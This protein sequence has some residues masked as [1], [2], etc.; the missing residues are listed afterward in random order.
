M[1]LTENQLR[2]TIRSILAEL[3]SR[4]KNKKGWLQHS[5]EQGTGR[6]AWEVGPGDEFEGDDLGEADESE[7]DESEGEDEN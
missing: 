5:L 6:T 2:K 7:T 3:M 4:R 1:Q